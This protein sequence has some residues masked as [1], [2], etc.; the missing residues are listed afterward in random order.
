MKR[1]RQ[2]RL[3]PRRF[4]PW[5]GVALLLLCGVLGLGV[6]FTL[7]YHDIQQ[8]FSVRKWSIPSRV[9]S[10]S[11]PI[12]PGQSLTLA[13]I[14]QMLQE[15]R[16]REAF[17]EPLQAGEFRVSGANL[18]V[19]LREFRFPGRSIP[20]QRV[21]FEFQRDRLSRIAGEKEEVGFLE[22]EPL[23]MARLFG[24]QR[25]SRLLVNV[26][27]LKP[28]VIDAILA[29]EDRRF[30]EHAGMD[31][32]S[33]LRALWADLTAGR[34]VQGGSTITQQ[35]VKNYFLQPERNLRRKIH[36]ALMALVLEAFHSKDEILE[37]YL[38]EI[39]LGQRGSVAIHG[40]GEAAR[41][42]FGRNVENLS[43]AEAATIAGMICGPNL[44]S[45]LTHSQASKERRNLVL[46]QMLQQ[47]KITSDEYETA[48]GEPLRVAESNLPVSVAPYF[49]DYVRQ[50]LGELYAP[51][52]LASEGLNIYTTLNP[53]ISQ[54]AE[55][56][57]RDGLVELEKEV[58]RQKG[59]DGAEPLQAAMIVVQPKTGAILALVGGRD[60][61]ESTFNRAVLASRQPGSA[62]K[63]FVYL[64]GMDRFSPV[65][66]LPDEPLTT[67]VDGVSWSPKNYDN[68]FRGRVMLRHAVEESLNLPAVHVAMTVGLDNIVA[69]LRSFDIRS[70]IHPVPSIALGACEVT[71]LE[72]A[73]AYAV[74][75]N[76]GQQA[77]LLSL[78]EVV[79]EQGEVQE[80]RNVNLES[81]TTP[82][83]AFL[84]TDLL[85]GVMERGTGRPIKK[86]G[87][88]FPCAGKTGTTSDYRDSWFIGYTTDLLALVWVGY[89]ANLPTNLTGAT[90][91]GKIWAR[92]FNQVKPWI[93]P[94]PFRPPPGIVQ[95]VVCTV[96]GQL[97]TLN[98]PTKRQEHFLS[99]HTVEDY[100]TLHGSTARP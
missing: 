66:W 39:Y 38:N 10:A 20:A 88:D 63:P 41:Y 61:G 23:E 13:I 58:L 86:L 68:R 44:Y 43:V 87:L 62:I 64:A 48:R 95:R 14:K 50:Q 6:I 22:L 80:R 100:C 69:T 3:F 74:L 72:L 9:F 21:Q 31:P 25:E 55:S 79:T 46:K 94:Q 60:Y 30:Y 11:A 42:Y 76:D 98:C 7:L 85:Q 2:P 47:E 91:A 12:Y 57:V 97:A 59:S 89:D 34:V 40:I 83:K 28:H 65:D 32:W 5:R 53:E 71:P 75:D 35:L 26:R 82:A 33:I 16:Y 99:E 45:P 56:A 17:K 70:S 27:Q 96:S 81:V 90:G 24:P 77:F 84:M 92:F 49:V 67:F 36:E 29:V 37:M 8:R 78:K 19:H 93:N 4:S 18:M 73:R 54:A 1:H 52:V 15:R 51:E